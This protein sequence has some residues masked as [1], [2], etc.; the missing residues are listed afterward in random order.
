MDL[1]MPVMSG[2]EATLYIRNEM[3]SDIP[4]I[5]LTA[6]LISEDIK[7]CFSAGMNDYA[8]KPIDDKL[9]YRKMIQIMKKQ[10]D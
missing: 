5:A 3:K 1:Q 9:L 8:S 6:D 7:K 4:I 10:Q 2:I